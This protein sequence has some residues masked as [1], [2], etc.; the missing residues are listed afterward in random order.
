MRVGGDFDPMD[1]RFMAI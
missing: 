1:S